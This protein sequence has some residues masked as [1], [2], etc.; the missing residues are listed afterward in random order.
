MASV[1]E[2][3]VEFAIQP[4]AAAPTIDTSEWPL[5]LKD[6]DKREY[7]NIRMQADV[8]PGDLR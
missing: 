6:Y 3:S 5:L 1:Q 2:G 8:R 4:Q 7:A